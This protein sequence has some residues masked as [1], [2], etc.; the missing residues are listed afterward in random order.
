M[1]VYYLHTARQYGY[2]SFESNLLRFS[3]PMYRITS[4]ALATG[5][6]KKVDVG[7][8]GIGVGVK[9]FLI[10]VLEPGHTLRAHV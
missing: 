5:T 10:Q 7:Y 2:G 9:Q 8:I 6:Y 1:Y 3:A 4:L